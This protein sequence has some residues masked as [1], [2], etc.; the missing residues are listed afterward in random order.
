MPCCGCKVRVPQQTL[1]SHPVL[2]QS[3]K[4]RSYSAAKRIPAGPFGN[5]F[6]QLKSVIRSV[7]GLLLFAHRTP[8]ES[9]YDNPLAEVIQNDR[10]SAWASQNRTSRRIAVTLSQ[11]VKNL[12][13][14]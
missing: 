2:R 11:I 9:R 14:G 3:R 4:S 6:I 1:R 10:L 7:L 8:F 12:G 5:R 13:Q